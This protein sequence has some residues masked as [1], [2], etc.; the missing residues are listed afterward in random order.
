MK[1]I[2]IIISIAVFLL[3]LQIS[4]D[5]LKLIKHSNKQLRKIESLEA[6]VIK[7]DSLIA[8]G[9]FEQALQNF[10]IWKL[11]N[12]GGWEVYSK[13]EEY[14]VWRRDEAYK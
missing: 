13:S 12:W 2:I 4:F 7:M 14:N 11:D 5:H 8:D 1:K 3:F 10:N 9:V 6:L